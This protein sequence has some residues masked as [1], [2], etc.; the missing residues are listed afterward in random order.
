METEI[1]RLNTIVAELIEDN[2]QLEPLRILNVEL[3]A[4]LRDIRNQALTGSG[5]ATDGLFKIITLAGDAIFK[6]K[7]P[8]KDA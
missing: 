1:E 3:L 5:S 6:A 4:A 7:G 2:Q 8:I